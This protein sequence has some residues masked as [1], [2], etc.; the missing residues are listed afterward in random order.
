MIPADVFRHPAINRSARR[1]HV[2]SH[3]EG[4]FWALSGPRPARSTARQA[5]DGRSGSLRFASGFITNTT[6]AFACSPRQ[7]IDTGRPGVIFD[8][9]VTGK[10]LRIFS[11]KGFDSGFGGRPSPVLPCSPSQPPGERPKH[12]DLRRSKS[13]QGIRTPPRQPRQPRSPAQSAEAC[14]GRRELTGSRWATS[15]RLPGSAGAAA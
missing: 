8:G 11:R 1:S 9:G 15:V 2:N 7:R 14:H 5:L 6:F 4:D 13:R 12:E 10:R 3:H